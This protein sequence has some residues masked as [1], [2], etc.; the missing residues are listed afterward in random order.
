MHWLE[1]QLQTLHELAEAYD[2]CRA[3]NSDENGEE[4]RETRTLFIN[5]VQ[6]LVDTIVKLPE[7]SGCVAGHDGF[8][9]AKAGSVLDTD[10][11][12]AVIQES[13]VIAE[14]CK[15][16]LNLGSIK[17]IVIVGENNKIAM[18]SVAPVTLCIL[19]PTHCNLADLLS[20]QPS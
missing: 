7:I 11:L 6:S 14:R 8:I 15:S 17:Q 19:S 3:D 18:I 16:Q 2:K 4:I 5:N 13:M 20:Q 1:T 12:G 10:A 9:L